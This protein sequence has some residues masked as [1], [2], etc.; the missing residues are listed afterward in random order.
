MSK[1]NINPSKGTLET[2]K[3]ISFELIALPENVRI[4]MENG[5]DMVLASVKGEKEYIY[6]TSSEY[7]GKMDLNVPEYSSQSIFSIFASIEKKQFNGS[8][9]LIEICPAAFYIEDIVDSAFEGDLEISPLI[10]C[11]ESASIKLKCSR[12]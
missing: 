6:P 4:R 12:T 1:L 9:H 11:N 10:D 5:T 2:T 3:E 7:K 8:Y